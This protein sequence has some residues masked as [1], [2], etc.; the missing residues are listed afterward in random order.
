MSSPS[1]PTNRSLETALLRVQHGNITRIVL[2][3]AG[4]E[5]YEL[6]EILASLF[7]PALTGKI[8]ALFDPKKDPQTVLP[9]SLI[10]R[11]PQCINNDCTYNT[12]IYFSPLDT[13]GDDG[14]TDI[15]ETVNMVSLP[16]SKR[17]RT[18]NMITSNRNQPDMMDSS[19]S[20]TNSSPSIKFSTNST[21]SSTTTSITS[22]SPILSSTTNSSSSSLATPNGSMLGIPRSPIHAKNFAT[23]ATIAESVGPAKTVGDSSKKSDSPPPYLKFNGSHLHIGSWHIHQKET[24][25]ELFAI[26]DFSKHHICWYFV[27]VSLTPNSHDTKKGNN[28]YSIKKHKIQFNFSD[29]CGLHLY[30]NDGYNSLDLTVELKERPSLY[31]KLEKF[32]D[33]EN[34]NQTNNTD[35]NAKWAT[36]GNFTN[37][38][39]NVCKRH[40]VRFVGEE[41]KKVD[42]MLRGSEHFKKIVETGLNL[43]A[44]MDDLTFAGGKS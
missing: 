2:I 6:R 20:A 27:D 28:T 12:I 19:S 4:I 15:N 18:M 42:T 38:Q 9:L 35:N 26:F 44:G 24:S 43:F 21:L 11:Y 7:Q 17:K 25:M 37:G 31:R 32:T 3:Y 13:S 5:V 36:T 39:S 34:M 29:V 41:A 10:A 1:S 40:V 23:F 33:K 16:Q 22:M 14:E 30:S 8:V